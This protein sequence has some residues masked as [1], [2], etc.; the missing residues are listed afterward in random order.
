MCQ[1]SRF[2]TKVRKLE[3]RREGYAAEQYLTLTESGREGGDLKSGCLRGG[4]GS[5]AGEFGRNCKSKKGDRVF[6]FDCGRRR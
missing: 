5:G 4:L 2:P 1:L 3:D 6:L